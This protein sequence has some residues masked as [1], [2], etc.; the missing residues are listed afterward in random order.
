MP[1]APPRAPGTG[2]LWLDR[3]ELLC[4][5]LVAAGLPAS[6]PA[7]V[8]SRGS[9]PDQESVTGTLADLAEL[10]AA[11]ESPALVVVGEVVSVGERLAAAASAVIAA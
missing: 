9:L 6:T 3:L 11:L 2:P 4:A 1:P 10:A 8:V 7:A 5:G